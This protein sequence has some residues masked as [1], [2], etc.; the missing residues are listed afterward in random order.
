MKNIWQSSLVKLVAVGAMVALLFTSVSPI[1]V[2]LN[3]PFTR[4]QIN[5]D[6]GYVRVAMASGT[7]DYPLTQ[8]GI[9]NALNALPS[10]GGKIN[11]MNT[12]N[13]TI[14]FSGTVTRAIPNVI[15]Q[16]SGTAAVF[17]N[18]GVTALFSTSGQTGWIF[19]DIATDAGG[20]TGG[21]WEDVK[22]GNMSVKTRTDDDIYIVA[23]GSDTGTEI[24]YALTNYNSSRYSAGTWLIS[25][26]VYINQNNTSISGD[27][28][29][30]TVFQ[31]ANNAGV[32]LLSS[33]GTNWQN[34][35]I[36]NIRLDGNKANNVAGRGLVYTGYSGL[37][38]NIWITNF[39]GNGL[40]G[41]IPAAGSSVDNRIVNV[42]A[43]GNEGKGIAWG[44]GAG[45][46]SMADNYFTNIL[47]YSNTGDGIWWGTAALYADGLFSYSNGG[48]GLVVLGSYSRIT[49]FN[50]GGDLLNGILLQNSGTY[51]FTATNGRVIDDSDNGTGQYDAIRPYNTEA[52]F[53]TADVILSDVTAIDSRGGGAKVNYAFNIVGNFAAASRFQIRGGLYSGTV[54]SPSISNLGNAFMMVRDTISPVVESSGS[55]TL[56]NGQTSV[57]FAHGLAA[58]PGNVQIAWKENPTNAIADWWWTATS[59]NITLNGVDPGASNL[60]FSWRAVVGVGN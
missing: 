54:T 36:K 51:L 38:E 24:Q 17:T 12:N 49:N 1:S 48:N 55:A 15:W 56:L 26:T 58:T 10:V 57:S 3:N 29:G 44:T 46:G 30:N 27:D 9:Q 16:G 40:D 21:R 34:T 22:I 52:G 5:L 39:S 50:I 41:V 59:S 4:N 42:T 28:W 25:A 43:S 45:A 19:R 6:V 23:D 35:H 37:L 31:L 32:D 11:L 18:N 60:D 8:T 20:I 53:I 47:S 14:T 2:R 7:F 33:N 13:A